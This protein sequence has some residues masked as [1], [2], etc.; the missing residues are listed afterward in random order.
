MVDGY[1]NFEAF[2]EIAGLMGS[3]DTPELDEL[4]RQYATL[5]SSLKDFSREST[6][7]LIASLLTYPAFHANTIRLETLQQLAQR[8]CKG[9][10]KP[11][12]HRL[13]QW[14][15]AAGKGWAAAM[16]D[17]V[18]DVFVSNVV[19]SIGNSRVFEGIWE[20]NDFWLQQALNA[21]RAFRGERWVQD[22]FTEVNGLLAMS[23]EIARRCDLAR[24]AMGGGSTRSDLDVPSESDLEVRSAYVHFSARDLSEMRASLGIIHAFVHDEAPAAGT[25]SNSTLQRRPLQRFGDS[26][27]VALPAAISPAIRLHVVERVIQL[28]KVEEYQ[29]ALST[30]QINQLFVDGLENLRAERVEIPDLPAL[31]PN[32]P[33]KV[34]EVAKFDDGKFTHIIFFEDRVLDFPKDGVGGVLDLVG[35][36][37]DLIVQHTQRCAELLADRR[38]YRGGLTIAVV[39]GLGRAFVFGLE[40]LPPHWYGAAFRLPDFVALSRVQRTRLLDIWKL[41]EQ[42]LSLRSRG[43]DLL[44]VSG[45]LNLLG[46]W[47]G[48]GRRLVPRSVPLDGRAMVQVGTD[49]IA[50]VRQEMRTKYDFH[51]VPRRNPDVWVSV[52]RYNIDSY[53]RELEG[54]LIYADEQDVRQGRLRGLVETQRRFW[55]LSTVDQYEERLH[56]DIQFRIWEA[57]LNWLPKFVSVAEDAFEDL[58]EGPIEIALRFSDL[59][60]WRSESLRDLPPAPEKLPLRISRKFSIIELTLPVGFL[61]VFAQPKNVA[62]RKLLDACFKGIA[63]LVGRTAEF[64]RAA[65]VQRIVSND[66][67][68][69]FHL[70]YAQ[71]FRQHTAS[72]DRLQ[73][74]FVGEG[75]VNFAAVGVV[76]R[77]LPA[78]TGKQLTGKEECNRFLH[79]VVDDCWDRTR[80]LLHNL[81]RDSVVTL[82]LR[83]VEAVEQDRHQWELTA[84]AVMATHTDRDEVVTAAGKRE[85][86]RSEAALVSRVI[87]E[88]AVCT[89]PAE[90]NVMSRADFDLLL[91]LVR[92]LLYAATSS[93]AINYGLTPA[94]LALFPNGEFVADDGYYKTIIQPYTAEQ[95]I[96]QFSAAAEEYTEYFTDPAKKAAE[97]VKPFEEAFVTAFSAEYGLTP[98]EL[99]DAFRAIEAEGMSDERLVI[100]R[101]NE[102]L[103]RS[104]AAKGGLS[105]EKTELLLRNFA[106]WPRG[107]WERTPPGFSAKDWYPWRYRRRLSLLARPLVRTGEAATDNVIFAPG[108]VRDCVEMLLIRLLS[109]RLPAEGFHSTA[110]RSWIGEITRRRGDEFE[111]QVGA[112]LRKLGFKA[113]VSQSMAVF[114]ADESY[115][116]VDVFAWRIGARDIFA[117]ECKRLRAAKTVAEIGEQLHEF[118]GTEMDRLARHLRRCRWL[119]EHPQEVQRVTGLREANV[120]IVPVLVTSTIVPMQFVQGLPL[121]PK[122]IVPFTRLQ[123][124][125]TSA[126]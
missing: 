27:I 28:G 19:T 61:R 43:V 115:G 78:S 108:L 63:A 6:M 42:E 103:R 33:A 36:P 32:S 58:A 94:K 101:T 113:I 83:N 82:A 31:P 124:W 62:E 29:R 106:L 125:V 71:N 121:P 22:L 119:A 64:D 126:P 109:G 75:D 97:A 59:E 89:C 88:M 102:Q 1:P 72:T 122:Q 70:A 39:G 53:F 51:A 80:S 16:E 69:F 40:K 123:Q 14:L 104:L 99:V 24:F 100:S 50:G 93:D 45:E 12:R 112:E 77:L 49:F 74:R 7:A 68:R 98:D 20:A 44:N 5:V 3:T 2:A 90:G 11:T 25:E 86:E 81:T 37:G 21:L 67:A 41:K 46:F 17:P 84:K 91:G 95:F 105:A 52:R 34:Q 110:M 10:N 26:V 85:N 35:E 38:D 30:Q 87:V 13:V 76:Q 116:D 9:T 55:W 79:A 117:I 56:R 15:K 60:T 107:S 57:L 48:H 23:E 73:S 114:G 92:L 66:D 8:N 47:H 118:E 54:E 65:A 111:Q 120:N 4:E 18:E 96:G